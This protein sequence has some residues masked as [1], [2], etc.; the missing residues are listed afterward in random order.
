MVLPIFIPYLQ[1]LQAFISELI[2]VYD[3][4]IK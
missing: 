4:K 3:F 1:A 2:L